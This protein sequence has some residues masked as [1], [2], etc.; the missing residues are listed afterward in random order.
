MCLFASRRR[1][2]RCA[3][4]TGVQTCAPPIYPLYAK[5]EV[6]GLPVVMMAGGNAGPDLSYTEPSHIDRVLG[7]FPDLK[8]VA[9]HGAWPWAI[10]SAACR[11]RVCQYVW[12]SVVAVSFQYTTLPQSIRTS[13]SI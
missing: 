13:Y 10:G 5:C 2:T 1:H 7:D 11:E 3:L 12:I 4:V 8:V 9:T 6:R